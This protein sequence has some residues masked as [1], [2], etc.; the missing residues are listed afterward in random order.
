MVTESFNRGSS[1]SNPQELVPGDVGGRGPVKNKC[2]RLKD[3]SFL[4]PASVE[5]PFEW[6]CFTDRSVDGGLTWLRGDF[7][8]LDPR[9]ISGKGIIQPTLWE[10]ETG[11]VHMLTRSTEGRIFSS[12]SYNK[13]TS[14]DPCRKTLLPNNNSGIDLTRLTDGRLVLV[15]NPVSGDWAARTPISIAVSCDNGQNWEKLM[16]LEHDGQDNQCHAQEYSYSAIITRKL[17]SEF[18]YPAIIS[19]EK[20]IFLTYTWQRKSIA[21]WQIE[22]C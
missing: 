22:F 4:A 6:R 20:T 14:W 13:G 18:S 17:P 19:R 2:I 7:V 15:Y 21:F 3:G 10:D 12:V 9:K 1:W 16:D 11:A 5:T 8:P